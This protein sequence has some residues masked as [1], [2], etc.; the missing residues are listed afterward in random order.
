MNKF[1]IECEPD[2]NDRRVVEKTLAVMRAAIELNKIWLRD[3]P[4]DVCFLT[5]DGVKYDFAKETSLSNTVPIKTVPV[6]KRE[7]RG[8]CIDFVCFDVAVREL[9][10]QKA[11]P[12][13]TDGTSRGLFHV[14]TL[15]TNGDGTTEIIDPA[16]EVANHGRFLSTP[17]L[18]AC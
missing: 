1:L 8:L 13:V 9:G 3:H 12:H 6:L 11:E 16:N 18:C 10:G 2:G 7:K 14:T 4:K 15:V 5:C 17:S